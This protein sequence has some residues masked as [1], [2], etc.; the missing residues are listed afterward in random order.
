MAIPGLDVGCHAAYTEI[1]VLGIVLGWCLVTATLLAVLP[2][3]RALIAARSSEG[4]SLT[5]PALNLGYGVLNLCSTLTHKWPSLQRCGDG[6]FA[7]AFL[8]DGCAHQIVDLLQQA[9]S[10]LTLVVVLGLIVRYPPH[11]SRRERC[12]AAGTVAGLAC[13][14]GAACAVSAALPCSADSSMFGQVCCV[15]AGLAVT[16]AFAPQIAE[17]WRCRGRGS[18]SYVFYAIQVVGCAL[19]FTSQKFFLHDSVLVWG[20]TAV[21]G[22]MQAVVLAIGLYFRTGLVRRRVGRGSSSQPMLRDALCHLDEHG[23]VE[24]S[25]TGSLNGGGGERA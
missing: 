25:R 7:R 11:S 24:R 14:I 9:S 1:S 19:V 5:T 23:D 10:A 12:V 2:Q 17:S 20:P 8:V 6:D 13:L 3:V 15:L 22:T 18:L 4:I 16:V 21:A